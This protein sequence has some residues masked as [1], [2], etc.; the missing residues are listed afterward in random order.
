YTLIDEGESAI[1]TALGAV[2]IGIGETTLDEGLKASKVHI[3]ENNLNNLSLTREEE[4]R[5]SIALDPVTTQVS[6]RMYTLIDE[7]E[8]AISTALGAVAIGIGETTLDEGLKASKVHIPENNLDN[9]SLTREEEDRTSVALDPVT[10]QVSR[11]MLDI[12]DGLDGTKRGCKQ[13]VVP[14]IEE[15]AEAEEEQVIAPVMDME[16][17]LAALFGEDDDFED[18]DFS[19]DD[20]EGVEEEEVWR[21]PSI[22]VAE[23]PFLPYLAS[24]LFAPPFVIEDLSTR[25]GNLEYGHR[26]LVQRVNQMVHAIDRWEQVGAQVEQGQQ[27]ATQRDETIVELTQESTLMRCILGLE[28]RTAA[29]EKRPP[30]PQ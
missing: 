12:V 3:P 20:S 26:Q 6:R 14:A 7:G 22:A 25:L 2:A 30:G 24:G 4:D 27:T 11:R 28:R 23:G 21:G 17:D 13:M 29:L 19:D 18:D 1:S 10:T 8:S 5:T 16:E 9:L 15:V